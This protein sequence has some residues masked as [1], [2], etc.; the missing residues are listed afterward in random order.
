[1]GFSREPLLENERLKKK[2]EDNGCVVLGD[3]KVLVQPEG[4]EL[5]E[6]LQ[7]SADNPE[8]QWTI[9]KCLKERNTYQD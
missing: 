5:V 2:K 8:M 3:F 7:H 4:R 6:Y 9:Q 1:M